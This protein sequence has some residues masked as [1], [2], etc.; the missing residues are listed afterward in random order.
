[1]A[2]GSVQGISNIKMVFSETVERTYSQHLQ[3][4]DDPATLQAITVANYV[5]SKTAP[6]NITGLNGLV[7]PDAD[8]MQNPYLGCYEYNNR[9]NSTF[10]AFG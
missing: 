4:I 1:M 8:F 3:G 7:P 6:P 10:E 9:G 2:N 5:N